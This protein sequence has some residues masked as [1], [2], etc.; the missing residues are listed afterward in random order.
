VLAKQYT[1]KLPAD[2]DMEI[3]RERVRAGGPRFDTVKG[4][5]F[6]AFLITERSRGAAAN[7]YSPFY[8]WHETAAAN[9]FLFGDGFA[10]LEASFG[11]PRIEHWIGL[12]IAFGSDGPARSATREDVVIRDREALADVRLREL[13]WLHSR[14]DD[15]RGLHV[16]AVAL[17]P[18][19]WTMVR[20]AAWNTPAGAQTSRGPGTAYEVLHLSLPDRDALG[21]SDREAKPGLTPPRR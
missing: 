13:E 16:A 5:A 9:A 14:A 11:R 15:P 8:I 1:I 17:D 18:Q 20:F 10:G 6:K 19:R 7:R 12:D 3:I 2:Y 21:G 4:L